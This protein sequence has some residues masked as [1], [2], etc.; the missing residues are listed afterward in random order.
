MQTLLIG[1]DGATFNVLE[2]LWENGSMP[3]LK[4]CV[5]R[6]VRAELQSVI[7][8]L[9][10]PAWTSLV[11][12]RSPGHH[13]I[14]DFV[15]VTR[16]ADYMQYQMATSTDIQSE[17]LWSIVSR[18][19][20]QVATLNFPVMFPPRPIAG[21][22][23]PG[24][25]TWRHLRRAVYPPEFYNQ[26]T[27][28]SGF[29]P[30]ELVLDI[31]HERKAIQ[32]LEKE[33]YE[34]WIGFHIRREE[35]W[36]EVVRFLSHN[37]QCDLLAVLFDGVDKLQHICWRFVEPG[38]SLA[39]ASPWE[40]KI[41]ELCVTYFRR[42]DEILAE[43]VALAGRGTHVIFTSDHGFGPTTELFYVNAWLSQKGYLE[44][45]SDVPYDDEGKMAMLESTRSPGVLFDWTK[46][47]ACAL[48][49]G[50]NGIYIK[51]ANESGRPGVPP[52]E[53]DSFREQL[54]QKLLAFTDPET[55]EPVVTRVLT[56]EEAFSGP[57]MERAPD[58][59]LQ[60]RDGG[61]IS[62]LNSERPLK[63]RREVMGTHRPEGIFLA[64]GPGIRQKL[65]FPR[66]SILDVAPLILYSMR[67][68][69]PSD[70]EGQLPIGIFEEAFVRAVPSQTGQSSIPPDQ[71]ST[72][73]EATQMDAG[74]EALIMDRLK[75][76]G[77][78][79]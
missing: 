61:F 67:L 22:S 28:L 34:D 31:E 79:E 5:D 40:R 70:L 36:L 3:F 53:Y 4:A 41:H 14:F 71:S 45:A 46:T 19:G 47:K 64:V 66:L 77:Y 9:T 73:P 33:Q 26:L 37:T 57:E 49:S 55:G 10:P 74:E 52:E 24:F 78:L 56:R 17:T 7:P 16:T 76:L 13:G 68:P 32:V 38:F 48:T 1:L 30:K 62:I 18:Q 63:R 8:N 21:Y 6:G 75:A 54:K 15:R 42:L 39:D 65:V 35:R 11:T 25:V 2:P 29:N 59:T 20:R 72:E 50:S 43:V 69:I 58:L 12:G 23:I 60:L 27:A 51:V 44:W